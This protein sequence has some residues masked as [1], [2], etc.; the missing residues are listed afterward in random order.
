MAYITAGHAMSDI[1]TTRI[2]DD[3]QTKALSH[4]RSANYHSYLL[5]AWRADVEA[6]WR[7]SLE[8]IPGDQRLAFAGLKAVVGF[9]QAQ[10]EGDECIPP[11]ISLP[12]V[13]V[14]R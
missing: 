11:P 8:Y 14:E 12:A 6:P 7:F 3:L 5:R 9:L 2:K 13:Q 10:L 4:A 1:E